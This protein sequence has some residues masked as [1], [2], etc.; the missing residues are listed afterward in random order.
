MNKQ[1]VAFL[2]QWFSDY[3]STFYTSDINDQRNISL[4]EAHTYRVCDNII[5]LVKGL[6]VG[7]SD[8]N[9][10]EVIAL[11]H[12]V[13]RFS[14]YRQYKT[15]K[16]ADSVNHAALGVK[17]LAEEKVL[18]NVNE[19]DRKLIIRAIGLHNVFSIPEGLDE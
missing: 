18:D 10:A 1:E 19:E 11:F 2:K 4:K 5:R 15:F 9:L 17:V 6:A 14:Q 7:D 13:G 8:T 12:D 3:C 16:D